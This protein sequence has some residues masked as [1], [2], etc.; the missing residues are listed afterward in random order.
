MVKDEKR[1]QGPGVLRESQGT[2][3][4][5]LVED[6]DGDEFAIA[7]HL[8]SNAVWICR[9]TVTFR[10]SMLSPSSGLR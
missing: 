6:L 4:N 7:G 8:G 3:N 5:I 9:Q 10:R 1:N 2:Q